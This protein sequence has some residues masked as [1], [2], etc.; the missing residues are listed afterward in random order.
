MFKVFL[1]YKKRMKM[2]YN[3]WTHMALEKPRKIRARPGF[4]PGTSRTL[5]ENHTPRPT[6]RCS[7]KLHIN[8]LIDISTK[9][10]YTFNIQKCPKV[11][12][13]CLAISCV[14]V[15]DCRL[16]WWWPLAVA[17]EVWESHAFSWRSKTCLCYV[18][19]QPYY[20]VNIYVCIPDIY[21]ITRFIWV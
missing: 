1:G 18:I 11:V 2:M 4:E 15:G 9:L 14:V 6:S 3:H 5:S 8:T 12:R 16:Y 20:S 10:A 13:G 17:G 19:K 7:S 21:V